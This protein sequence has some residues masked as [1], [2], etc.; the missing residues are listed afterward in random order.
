MY[1]L[2]DVVAP[3]ILDF[4][5]LTPSG[6]IPVLYDELIDGLALDDFS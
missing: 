1:A 6:H 4:L 2:V 3:L 5:L